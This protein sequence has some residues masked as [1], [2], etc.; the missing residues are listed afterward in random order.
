MR[1]GQ[2]DGS[3]HTLGLIRRLQGRIMIRPYRP[4]ESIQKAHRLFMHQGPAVPGNVLEEPAV[5]VPA[6]G[7]G[8]TRG[9]MSFF[10]EEVSCRAE[11]AEQ[12]RSVGREKLASLHLLSSF[13][14]VPA[15]SVRYAVGADHNS[16]LPTGRCDM[17]PTSTA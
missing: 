5:S 12:S 14:N 4:T 16:P 9:G 3:A 2:R 15:M 1:Q 11:R 6:P 7:D 8:W 13:H 10:A 17:E